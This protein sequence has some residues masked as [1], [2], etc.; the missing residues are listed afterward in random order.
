MQA[1]VEGIGV[2]VAIGATGV[3][4]LALDALDLGV[5]AVIVFGLV[6]S[7]TWTAVAVGVYRSYT[8]ALADEMRRRPLV[9]SG[10]LEAPAV[11][12]LLRSDDARDVRLGL[13]LLAGIASPRRRSSSA[14]SP[15][16]RT[17]RSACGRWDSS[18]RSAT[19][20]R[21]PTPGRSPAISRAPTTPRI[22]GRRPRARIGGC[23]WRCSTTPTRRCASRRSMRSR[24]PTPATRR[25]SAASSRPSRTGAPRAGRQRRSRDSAT[26]RS[27]SSLPRSPRR[28]R[29]RLPLVRAAAAVAAE[30]GVGIVAPAL[31][32]PDR[33]V[34]LAALDAL[35]AAGG[36]GLVASD[37]LDGVFG[38]AAALAARALAARTAL[39]DHDGP[40]IRALDDEI[41]LARRLVIAVLAL[42]HGE[43]IRAAVRVVDHGE[44]ARRALGVEALDVVR[45]ARRGRG[46]AP[47]RAPRPHAGRA[48]GPAAAHPGRDPQEWIAD[49][50]DDP[51]GVW[52]SSWLAAC[53][54]HAA[55]HY[56]R[57]LPRTIEHELERHSYGLSSDRRV[58]FVP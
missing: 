28:A 44:G 20:G 51:E 30:H 55:E 38:D 3:L 27:R 34:V 26:T 12:A 32:D 33:S 16:T 35:D 29:R 57:V 15:S 7:V 17:R 56:R 23:S 9:A 13:D 1:V 46:R 21:P 40:L 45:L 50:T 43:R 49:I 14:G 52:R 47:A 37:V 41:D 4:L 54:H 2:P 24:P 25:S 10:D 36:R 18:R 22:G 48:D 31:D 58:D 53:A 39:A 6:L 5:G 8:R 19:C 42:R 11:G